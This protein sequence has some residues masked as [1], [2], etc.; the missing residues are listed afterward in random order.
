MA[1][2]KVIT[3]DADIDRASAAAAKLSSEPRATSVDY[4]PGPGLNLLILKL[5]NGQRR[6]FP[7]EDIQG[8]QHAT[9]AQIA[10]VRITGS[11]TGLH[12]P[13]LDLD[14]YVPNLL[15]D[16]YG[17]RQWMAEIGRRG[18]ATTSPAKRKSARANGRKGGRPRKLAIA[19]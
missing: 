12:W 11:G 9:R 1:R 14:L 6:V 4:K 7:I 19:G 15:R 17:T 3:T 2:H 5:N 18:G 13:S 16:I 10:Q 8:L